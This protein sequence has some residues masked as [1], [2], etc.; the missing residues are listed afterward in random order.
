MRRDDKIQDRE[1]FSG[2]YRGR[3]VLI[4][5]DTGFK[6]SWMSWW[7]HRLGAEVTGFALPP[8]HERGVYNAARIDQRIRHLDGN[9]RDFSALASAL[10][11]ARPE[12]V[13]HLAAQAIVRESFERPLETT[14]TNVM[15]TVHLM[16]AVRLSGLAPAVVVVTSDKCY[17]NLEWPHGYREVDPMGGADVYSASKAAAEVLVA[18]YRRSFLAAGGGEAAQVA[19]ARAGNVIGPGDWAK[20]R[21]VVDAV[22][23]LFEGQPFV[24][25]NPVSTRPWQH[26]LEPLSGYLWLATRLNGEHGEDFAEAWNFGPLPTAAR[27]V[28]DL[29]DLLCAAWGGGQWHQEPSPSGPRE[30][31]F[32]RLCIDKAAARLGWSPAYDFDTAVRRTVAGYLDIDAA[33][34]PEAV[35]A[36]LEREIDIYEAAAAALGVEWTTAGTG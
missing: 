5:G 29:A 28:R 21:I 24:V 9:V 25:R 15:G 10:E 26:V 36:V 7:L 2:F 16:E 35:R 33:Q 22:S 27:S 17:E 6:G 20:D 3:R 12:V 4:T 34:G 23:A 30:A 13:F 14:A 11:Q 8:A 1:P 31:T 18:S 32:L 19:T